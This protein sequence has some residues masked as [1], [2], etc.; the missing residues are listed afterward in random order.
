MDSGPSTPIMEGE[1]APPQSSVPPAYEEAHPPRRG[2]NPNPPPQSSARSGEE[3]SQYDEGP[4]PRR[5]RSNPNPIPIH[6]L[7]DAA[8]EQIADKDFAKTPQEAF[9][10]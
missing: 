8:A 1:Q 10:E 5:G 4:P 9:P 7:F 6:D 2:R 3:G